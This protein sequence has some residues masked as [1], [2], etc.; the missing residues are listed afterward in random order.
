M[1]VVIERCSEG[2]QEA[3]LEAG[4]L[5]AGFW[6]EGRMP[7]AFKLEVWLGSW[8]QFIG[9]G[10]GEIFVLKRRGSGAGRGEVLGVFG[11]MVFPDANDGEPVAMEMFWWVRKECRGPG[12]QLFRAFEDW[13]RERRAARVIM[14]H[15]VSMMPEKFER[16]LPR[17]GYQRQE[18]HYSKELRRS[19]AG[20][21]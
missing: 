1:Q 10:M 16:V 6:V 17:W 2:G 20:K 21:D 18:V 7:G 9:L 19:G 4:R 12:L 14:V 11:A 5:G 15:Q 13:A 8:A 3:L